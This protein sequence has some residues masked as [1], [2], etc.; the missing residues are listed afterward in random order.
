MRMRPGSR[1]ASCS[2]A[3]P[4]PTDAVAIRL[5][6][7]ECPISGSASYSASSAT[8]AAAPWPLS[9]PEPSNSVVNAVSSP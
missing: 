3:S 7:Q 1:P 8:Q 6:P 9:S 2:S 5:W 4:A